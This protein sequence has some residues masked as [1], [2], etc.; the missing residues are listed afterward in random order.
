MAAL[1]GPYRD[2]RRVRKAIRIFVHFFERSAPAGARDHLA[3]ERAVIHNLHFHG[4][5]RRLF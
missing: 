1:G 5:N 2:L 4:E 3:L